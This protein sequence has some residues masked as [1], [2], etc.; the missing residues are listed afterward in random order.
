VTFLAPLRGIVLATFAAALEPLL[1]ALAAFAGAFLIDFFALGA[2]L[3]VDLADFRADD[4]ATPAL[5]A[6]VLGPFA[7]LAA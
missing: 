6:L 1:P 4:L 2:A 7:L 5:L 3:A